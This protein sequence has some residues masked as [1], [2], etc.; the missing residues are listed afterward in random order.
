MFLKNLTKNSLF[1]FIEQAIF[2]RIMWHVGNV[3]L[4]YL[5]IFHRFL[6][7]I[8]PT[9]DQHVWREREGL[10]CVGV[11]DYAS[12]DPGG[13]SHQLLQQMDEGDDWWHLTPLFVDID[14]STNDDWWHLTPSFI[15]MDAST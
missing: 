1:F 5:Y 9:T 7:Y 10:R 8:F 3:N 13:H 4:E 15:D 11:W 14:A 12:A 6:F 2:F